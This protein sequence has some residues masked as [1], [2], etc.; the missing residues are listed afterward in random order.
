MEADKIFRTSLFL[1]IS[2]LFIAIN[3]EMLYLLGFIFVFG[4]IITIIYVLILRRQ[5]MN[6]D[7]KNG[8]EKLLYM[9]GFISMPTIISLFY[10]FIHFKS[11]DY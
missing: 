6:D 8:T 4:I 5:V 9:R 11:Q 3:I 10:Y 1:S 2:G 7:R